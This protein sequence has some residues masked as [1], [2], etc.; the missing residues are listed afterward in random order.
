MSAN[1]EADLFTQPD[2]SHVGECPICFLP[3]PIDRTKSGLTGCCSQL[4]CLGCN[5]TNKNREIEQGLKQR[6]PYCREPLPETK[7]EALKNVKKRV[8]KNDPVAMRRTGYKHEGDY[9]T[10]MKY[11][12]KAAE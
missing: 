3:L 10:A 8:K 4:I 12:A 5:H 7:E 9:E 6:C 1:H 2:G 11:W